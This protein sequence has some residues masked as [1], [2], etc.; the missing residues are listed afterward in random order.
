MGVGV[1]EVSLYHTHKRPGDS[2]TLKIQKYQA[3]ELDLSGVWTT[4]DDSD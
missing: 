2:G 4:E 3:F 1:I